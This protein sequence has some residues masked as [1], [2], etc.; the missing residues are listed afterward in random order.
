MEAD[1]FD[2]F[3]FPLGLTLASRLDIALDSIFASSFA[4]LLF[5]LLSL[6]WHLPLG[7]ASAI[8]KSF[9]IINHITITVVA[10]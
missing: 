9:L 3:F 6:K 5:A 2:A 4:T 8:S 10:A 1:G 7:S